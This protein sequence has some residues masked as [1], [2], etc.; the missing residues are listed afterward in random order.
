M[1]FDVQNED[2]RIAYNYARKLAE[3]RSGERKNML[4]ALFNALSEYEDLTKRPAT[5]ASI[6]AALMLVNLRGGGQ[7]SFQNGSDAAMPS[8]EV[9]SAKKA[10][11]DEV[12]ANMFRSDPFGDF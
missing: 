12:K 10:S 5:T 6:T 8:I 9:R 1:Q 2:E 3:R 11:A 4:V 7:A